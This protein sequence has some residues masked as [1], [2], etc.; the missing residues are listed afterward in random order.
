M[1]K[2]N[3]INKQKERK[4]KSIFERQFQRF[5]SS[6]LRSVN[7][8]LQRLTRKKKKNFFHKLFYAVF[9]T[10]I[11]KKHFHY[12]FAVAHRKVPIQNA[13]THRKKKFPSSSSTVFSELFFLWEHG[14]FSSFIFVISDR[15]KGEN[16]RK[17]LFLTFFSLPVVSID[18]ESTV[19][20][21]DIFRG[22]LRN[23][24]CEAKC[25]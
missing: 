2:I 4:Q 23:K 19:D 7:H 13:L 1:K 20:I 6:I 15:K 22:K 8:Y 16:M 3:K 14:R 11:M 24:K 9:V 10:N 18:A 21:V 5:F 25:V 17:V 12:R